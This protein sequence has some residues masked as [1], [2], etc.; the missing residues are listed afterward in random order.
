[1]PVYKEHSQMQPRSLHA[2][3]TV[4]PRPSQGLLPMLKSSFY[5]G[6]KFNSHVGYCNLNFQIGSFGHGALV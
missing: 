5:F 2:I 6:P 4:R 1:M 3:P